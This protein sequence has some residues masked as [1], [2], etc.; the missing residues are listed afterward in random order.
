ML[1]VGSA[2]V[3]VKLR[4]AVE[5]DLKGF[6]DFLKLASQRIMAGMLRLGAAEVHQGCQVGTPLGSVPHLIPRAHVDR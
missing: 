3:S 2:Q 5:R 1:C 6:S 4:R